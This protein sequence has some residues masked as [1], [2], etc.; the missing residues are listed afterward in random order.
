MRAI[1]VGNAV[2]EY[3]QMNRIVQDAVLKQVVMR[4]VTL[5]F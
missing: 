1:I 4:A 2:I 3:F 5:V